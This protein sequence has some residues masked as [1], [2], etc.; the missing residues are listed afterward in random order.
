[1]QELPS[2]EVDNQEQPGSEQSRTTPTIYDIEKKL[3]NQD[4]EVLSYLGYPR[5]NYFF[6][7]NP[8]RLQ[9]IYDEVTHDKIEMGHRIGALKRTKNKTEAE[10]EELDLYTMQHG[11][12]SKYRNILNLYLDSLALSEYIQIAHQLRNI[13]VI[14]NNQ[15]NEL[16]KNC[17]IIL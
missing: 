9:E 15:L 5:P 7:T 2:V 6:N 8:T 10:K 4:R 11:L 16:L 13:G 14:N 17:I 3:N 1:M 12:S